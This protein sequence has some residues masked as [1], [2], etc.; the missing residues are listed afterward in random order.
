MHDTAMRFGKYFFE[1]YVGETGKT[2]VDIGAQDVN[3]SLRDVAPKGV[4][5]I[6]VDFVEAK[7][8]DVVITD[9]YSLPFE[10][11][12]VDVCVCSSC[13][14]HSEHF[15]LLFEEIMRILKDDGV[16]YLNV[17]SNGQFHRYPVDCWRFYPD[18]GRA[19]QSWGRRKGYG[20]TLLESFTGNQ[21]RDIWNDFV[22]VF[23]KTEE[24]AAKYPNR[25]IDSFSGYTN[26][27]SYPDMSF[28]NFVDMPEDARR[29]SIERIA[30]AGL[31][32]MGA[33]RSKITG[34]YRIKA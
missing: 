22:A 30:K 31:Y 3:G 32:Y 17:P 1:K 34:D 24:N 4:T 12:S 10:D 23:V 26:A 2:I 14:E 20:T 25:I 11:N 6:G 13:F 9:P 15:W 27:L 29:W 18:S 21:R 19:L 33:L 7:G 16:F 8:V 28:R 5:Y